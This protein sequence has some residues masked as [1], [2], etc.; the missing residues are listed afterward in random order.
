MILKST[1]AAAVL[2]AVA[3]SAIAADF[4]KDGKADF[5]V[6]RPSTTSWISP[7]SSGD[8]AG[9]QWG[10]NT[11]VLVPAD[12]DGDGRTDFAVWRAENGVWYIH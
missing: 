10:R 7:S 2:L 5:A 1:L 9:F 8:A 6:F 12:Y 4:D 3:G 11:D